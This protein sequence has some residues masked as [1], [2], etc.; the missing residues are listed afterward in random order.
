MTLEQ[1][2]ET[3]HVR[4]KR[5]SLNDTIIPGFQF[6]TDMPKRQEYRSHI[7]DGFSDGR[8]GLC[9]LFTTRKRW[10]YAR[11][12][13][14]AA[15]FTI[16]QNA[17]TEGTALFD[18][19]NSHQAKLALRLARIKTIKNYS[20]TPTQAQLFARNAFAERARIASSTNTRAT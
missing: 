11:Q 20:G 7:F 5:D 14:L 1:F 13:L 2:A 4:T 15:G 19:E 6:C 18:P 12:K 9:L 3:Y 17:D 10:T 8:L 16:K